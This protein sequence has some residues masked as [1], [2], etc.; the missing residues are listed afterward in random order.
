[1]LSDSGHRFEISDWE[2]LRVGDNTWEVK[3][4]DAQGQGLELQTE[5]IDVVLFMPDHGHGTAVAVEVTSLGDGQYRFA[6]V[7]LRMPGYWQVSV[8]FSAADADAGAALVQFAVCV[9]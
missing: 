6:P 7:N 2:R 5:Q 1:V 3:L 9:E 4:S 8:R